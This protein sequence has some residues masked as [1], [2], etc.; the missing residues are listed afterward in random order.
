VANRGR[1]DYAGCHAEQGAEASD[2]PP[3]CRP[4]PPEDFSPCPTR[5]SLVQAGEVEQRRAA[6]PVP[7]L[8][9][10]QGME[11]L[12]AAVLAAKAL[13]ITDAHPDQHAT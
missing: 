11:E 2:L 12:L 10:R 8:R 1:A 13:A 5:F 9:P 7:R 3:A 4:T 6:V